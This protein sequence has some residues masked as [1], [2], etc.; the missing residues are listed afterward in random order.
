MSFLWQLPL[1]RDFCPKTMKT[2]RDK[3][4]GEMLC[5]YFTTKAE[6][7]TNMHLNSSQNTFTHAIFYKLFYKMA[8]KITIYGTCNKHFNSTIM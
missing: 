2:C 4:N 1:W 6:F 7:Y 5:I 3:G 8:Y